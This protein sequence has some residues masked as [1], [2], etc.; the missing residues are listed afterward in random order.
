VHDHE[1]DGNAQAQF[2]EHRCRLNSLHGKTV[3]ESDFAA[4]NEVFLTPI[5]AAHNALETARACI[6]AMERA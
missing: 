6:D 3:T 1:R 5:S 4:V 2:Q